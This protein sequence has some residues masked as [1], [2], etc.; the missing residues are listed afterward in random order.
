MRRRSKTSTNFQFRNGMKTAQLLPSIS[1]NGVTRFFRWL[2]LME[3]QEL[4]GLLLMS[5]AKH[6][7][8]TVGNIS[9]TTWTNVEK[10]FGHRSAM[11]GITS[12]LYDAKTGKVKNQITSGNW[13]VREVVKVD[14]KTNTIIFK[15]SGRNA[16]EDPYYIHYWQN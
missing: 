11:V 2:R 1:T 5:A 10:S 8:I 13:V 3:L 12:I 7:S 14:E 9:V 4:C 15:A 16:D 6:L